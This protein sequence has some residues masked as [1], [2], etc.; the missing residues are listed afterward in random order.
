M[1]TNFRPP[2]PGAHLD[3]Q[4]RVG[5]GILIRSARRKS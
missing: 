4:S 3:V 1:L 2:I 5:I